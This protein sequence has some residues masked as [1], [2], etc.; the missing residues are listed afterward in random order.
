M[1]WKVYGLGASRVLVALW[2]L[3]FGGCLSLGFWV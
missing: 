1:V 3:A 2:D